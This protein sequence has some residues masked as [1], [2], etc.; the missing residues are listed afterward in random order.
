MKFLNEAREKKILKN[1]SIS[2]QFFRKLK[3]NEVPKIRNNAECILICI[4]SC[5]LLEN[6]NESPP[7]LLLKITI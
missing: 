2:F 4:S 5:T 3:A 7:R 6:E 1:N